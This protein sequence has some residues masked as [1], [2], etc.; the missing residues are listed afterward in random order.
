MAV[1]TIFR[2]LPVLRRHPRWRRSPSARCRWRHC[3]RRAIAK[4]VPR[5]GPG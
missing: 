1:A 5:P 4:S 3:S 2:R